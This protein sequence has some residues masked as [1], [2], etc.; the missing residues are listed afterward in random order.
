MPRVVLTADESMMIRYV[1][2]LYSGFFST[3]PR[4]LIPDLLFDRVICRP[5]PAN[6]DGTTSFP[7]LSLRAVEAILR[8]MEGYGPGDVKIAH[9]LYLDRVVGPDTMVVGVSAKDPL[10]IGPATTSW[11]A[12]FGGIPQNRLKFAS[13]MARI[14]RLKERYGFKVVFG[15]PGAWQLEDPRAMD[16]YGIDYVVVGEGERIIPSLFPRLEDGSYKGPRVTDGQPASPEEVPSILG[17]TN[18]H[19]VEV[20]RG[21]GKGCRFCAPS[22]AGR[23]RSMPMEKI[24]ADAKVYLEHGIT[25]VT[26]QSEDTLRYGSNSMESDEE[27]VLNL[28][29]ELYK[30]GVKRVILTH[31]SLITFAHQPELIA[32]LT[33]LIRSHGLPGYGCQ[34]GLE[35]AS[36]RLIR[37]HMPNKCYPRPP[38]DWPQVV[39]E[40]LEVMRRH[41]WLPCCTLMMGLPGEEEEDVRQ[42]IDLIKSLRHYMA[43]FFPL[44]FLPV[45]HTSLGGEARCV[46][47][48]MTVAHWE[49][50]EVTW[51][52]NLRFFNR[53]FSYV[54]EGRFPS[55]RVGL[56]LATAGFGAALMHILRLR[57]K[58]A[59]KRAYGS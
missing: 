6:P 5:V 52:H 50:L 31:A 22:T 40:A 32:R 53:A 9:P 18:S 17:P 44:S 36:G 19:L 47:E 24:L 49:L 35:T 48:R 55:L 10:G 51:K 56:R 54:A 21:C 30:L 16:Y 59:A 41:R 8:G 38:E 12:L 25:S 14:R 29:K 45:K 33:K 58:E 46:R 7:V 4:R 11:T 23:L 13:L 43:F 37:M 2:S 42:T 28:Y 3:L 15:G 27:A 34:P 20:T 1:G 57:K 39:R 26:L